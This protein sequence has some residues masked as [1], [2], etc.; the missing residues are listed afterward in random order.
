MCTV[1]KLFVEL[2]LLRIGDFRTRGP[3]IPLELASKIKALCDVFASA[4]SE[5][6]SA[7]ISLVQ[8]S[9]SFVFLWFAKEMAIQA[10]RQNSQQAIVDGVTVLL[11]ENCKFDGR[12]STVPLALLYHSAETLGLNTNVLFT[13]AAQMTNH[14]ATQFIL[15]FLRRP[16]ATKS[17]EAFGYAEGQDSSGF[18]YVPSSLT[19]VNRFSPK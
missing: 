10:V 19:P 2:G 1:E 15:E 8:P 17:I 11:I 16:P 5:E 13:S 6:R 4:G 9:F 12:D 18:M 14:K 7:M 3:H